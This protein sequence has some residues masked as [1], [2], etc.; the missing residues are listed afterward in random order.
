MASSAENSGWEIN[1][2]N[3]R[4]CTESELSSF[5]L[6]APS[7]QNKRQPQVVVMFKLSTSSQIIIELQCVFKRARNIK[8]EIYIS[9]LGLGYTNFKSKALQ[10]PY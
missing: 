10:M 4:I 3:L 8:R 5:L 6:I 9:L 2:S 7:L 1:L